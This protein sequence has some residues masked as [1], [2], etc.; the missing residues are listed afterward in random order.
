MHPPTLTDGLHGVV[1]CDFIFHFRQVKDLS[2]FCNIGKGQLTAT[3][4]AMVWHVM[5]NDFV[6]L[7]GLAQGGAGVIFL[8]AR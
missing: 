7:R 6:G 3:R 2:G 1:L 4:L 8:P 5:Y